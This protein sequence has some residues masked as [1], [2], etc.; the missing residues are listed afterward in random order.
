MAPRVLSKKEFANAPEGRLYAAAKDGRLG[1]V[2][3]AI[4]EGA[5]LDMQHPEFGSTPL[6]IA[7]MN[8]HIEVAH[9][10]LE[11]EA[12]L[13]GRNKF[14]WTALLAATSKG[15]IVLSGY[16]VSRGADVK[17]ADKMGRTPLHNAVASGN[18]DLVKGMLEEKADVNAKTKE[19]RTAL[20]IE[21]N[22]KKEGKN[23]EIE[24]LLCEKMGLPFPKDAVKKMLGIKDR[25][26]AFLFPGQGS[27]C[28]GM[29]GWA[30][31][32][33]TAGPLL[34][35]AKEVLGYDLAY[36]CEFGPADKLDRVD[37]SQPALFLAAFCGL[38][39]LKE[40]EGDKVAHSVHAVAGL[41][42]GELAA[43]GVAGAIDFED[44]LRLAQ[45]RGEAMMK[46]ASQEGEEAQKMLS[47]IGLPEETLEELCDD[48]VDSAG[49]VCQ[50]SNRLFPCAFAV[51]GTEAAIDA[52]KTKAKEMEASKV[53]ELKGCKGAAFHTPCMQGAVEPFNQAL[54]ALIKEGKLRSPNCTVYSSQTGER[55]LPQTPPETIAEGL[56]R[57][58]TQSNFWED[59]MRRMIDE[60][61][62]DLY[63]IGPMKQLKVMMRHID[64]TFWK[65]MKNIEC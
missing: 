33:E 38:E 51:S 24:D 60:G 16:L 43:L 13:E 58:L 4:D 48:A 23:K 5:E 30:V 62:D 3:E 18:N 64:Y 19:G 46:A 37:I 42:V 57:G 9:Y 40:L 61:V 50:I 44:G 6:V 2:E 17:A 49:G 47:V 56:V 27:Q 53:S 54:Q 12:D 36:I 29:L 11:S 34:E 28:V 15:H 59:T 63:E 45:L 52:L 55:W 22:K 1:D 21:L 39:Q 65:R 26:W 14:G 32:H 10:L 20:S 8:N 31:D 7:C 25:T 41:S 35:K